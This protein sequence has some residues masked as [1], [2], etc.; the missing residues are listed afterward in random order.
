VA[1]EKVDMLTIC[2][3]LITQAIIDQQIG[4][5]VA[6]AVHCTVIDEDEEI[7]D[8][9]EKE[10]GGEEV[11]SGVAKSGKA[12][13]PKYMPPQPFD[14]RQDNTKSFISSMVLYISGQCPEFHTAESKIIFALSYIKGEKAQF[15]RNEVINKIITGHKP[16]KN[17]CDFLAKLEAQ[18]G[19]PN[20][21]ATAKGKL[22]VMHQGVKMVDEFILEFKLEALCSNL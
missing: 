22:E 17:F 19:N 16:F 18:F 2:M 21:G 1:E 6:A 8:F 11:G 5:P 13:L 10:E 14:S 9:E 7:G 4:P 20:P 3:G 12:C 15:W